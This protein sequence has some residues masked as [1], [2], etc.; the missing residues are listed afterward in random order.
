M[1]CHITLGFHIYSIMYLD[2][3]ISKHRQVWN[4]TNLYCLQNI[5]RCFLNN[6]KLYAIC[7]HL[8]WRLLKAMGCIVCR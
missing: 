8:Y 1:Q 4:P 2:T 7:T 5:N 6:S 3:V